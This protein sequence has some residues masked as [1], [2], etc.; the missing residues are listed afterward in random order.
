[1]IK[2]K[3]KNACDDIVGTS[4]AEQKKRCKEKVVVNAIVQLSDCG[5]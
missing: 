4:E 5:F 2:R 1:M 3:N